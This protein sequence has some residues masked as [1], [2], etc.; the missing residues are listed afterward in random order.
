[1]RA[2]FRTGPLPW[3]YYLPERFP[4]CRLDGEY[5]PAELA[6]WFHQQA[7]DIAYRFDRRNGYPYF[8]KQIETAQAGMQKA[9]G[10]EKETAV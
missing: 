8:Q 5:N 10:R 9:L 3:C 7:L 1:M 4:L 2:N 6:V